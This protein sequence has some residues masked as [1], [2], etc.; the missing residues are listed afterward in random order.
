MNNV[1]DI[2]VAKRAQNKVVGEFYPLQ[3]AELMAL[4]KAK[5]INNAAYVHLALRTE[6]PFCDRPVEVIPKEFALRWQIPEVSVYKAI[7]KLKELG[8]I[9]IKSGKLVIDWVIKADIEQLSIPIDAEK[10][11]NTEPLADSWSDP[12]EQ[13]SDRKESN[14]QI[15]K[16][17]IKFDNSLSDPIID[18][19]IRENYG[20]K[21]LSDI[22]SSISQTIQTDLTNQTAEDRNFCTNTELI[23]DK[24]VN[25]DNQ[26][27]LV[28]DDELE[29]VEVE[30][31]P[32]DVIQNKTK[33]ISPSKSSALPADLA[34][35]LREL[36]IPLDKRVLDAIANHDIS[37]AYGAAAHVENTWETINNPKSV[38]LFQLPQQPIEKLGSRLPEIGKELREQYTAIEEERKNPDY[39]QKS[40]EFF[41]RIREISEKRKQK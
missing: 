22:G 9:K 25:S 5:L 36:N 34:E 7:A 21:P 40:Q 10:V 29:V 30:Q 13:L 35:K 37:Q 4:R 15:G 38:F 39:Q 19:Q 17:I 8:L 2:P 27:S 28:N 6:N 18:Y 11:V 3:K 32:R 41:A 24:T 1:V 14:Y 20:L 26:K 16:K 12:D 33:I 23:K 31:V